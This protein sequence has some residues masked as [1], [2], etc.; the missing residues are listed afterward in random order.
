MNT[1]ARMR[2][3]DYNSTLSGILRYE[4]KEVL[5]Y[6]VLQHQAGPEP[7]PDEIHVSLFPEIKKH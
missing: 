3:S 6:R 4:D 2:F 1:W 7:L 5:L